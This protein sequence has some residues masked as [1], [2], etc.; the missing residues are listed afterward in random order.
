MTQSVLPRFGKPFGFVVGVFLGIITRDHYVYPY[1][2]RVQDLEEDFKEFQK[3]T[4]K[5]EK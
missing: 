5:M 2:L 4:D 1:P 3:Q